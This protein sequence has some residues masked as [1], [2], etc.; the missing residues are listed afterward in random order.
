MLNHLHH[1]DC[2]VLSVLFIVCVCVFGKTRKFFYILSSKDKRLSNME[3]NLTKGLP[4]LV[5]HEKCIFMN[6]YI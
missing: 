5:A 6:F 4:S 3:I 2:P 1:F